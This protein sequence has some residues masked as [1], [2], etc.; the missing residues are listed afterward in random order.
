MSDLIRNLDGGMMGRV[1]ENAA[2]GATLTEDEKARL[3]YAPYTFLKVT[4]F[5]IYLKGIVLG[6]PQQGW[7][8]AN[9][10]GGEEHHWEG[11]TYNPPPWP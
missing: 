9:I 8:W 4:W 7:A 1:L 11:P 6:I 2:T 10:E 3:P 5:Y